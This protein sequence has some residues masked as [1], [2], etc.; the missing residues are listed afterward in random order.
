MKTT[1]GVRT[2]EA[3]RK[4]GFSFAPDTEHVKPH[5]RQDAGKCTGTPTSRRKSAGNMGIRKV[6]KP[7]RTSIAVLII[8]TMSA[9]LGCT[10]APEPVYVTATPDPRVVSATAEARAETE[11]QVPG[12]HQGHGRGDSPHPG[13]G[14][15]HPDEGGRGPGDGN[16]TGRDQP[17][18]GPNADGDN[19][20][21]SKGRPRKGDGPSQER[22]LRR[23]T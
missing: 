11:R 14:V 5:H 21:P 1:T 3:R 17:V 9:V 13:A 18:R 23:G 10:Q 15:R 22:T 6:R 7:V 12:I 8:V 19:H 4:P 16:P 20:R 2:Q